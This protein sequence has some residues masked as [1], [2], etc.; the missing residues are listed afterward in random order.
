MTQEQ[1]PMVALAS[2]NDTHLEDVIMINELARLIDNRETDAIT[3]KLNELVN[4]TVEHFAGEE[5]MMLEKGFPPYQMHKTEH[6]KALSQMKEV[7]EHWKK[8]KDFN[9]LDHY[10][11]VFMPAWLVQHVST[12]DTVTARF[13]V[14]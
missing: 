12:M 1:L 4:H 14:S 7:V 9:A 11:K 5:K 6:D 13:L 10:I 8:H 3:L 2:M